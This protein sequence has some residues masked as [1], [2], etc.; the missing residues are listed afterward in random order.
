MNYTLITETDMYE[1]DT[2]CIIE[3]DPFIIFQNGKNELKFNR[4]YVV[5]FFPSDMQ[6]KK[7]SFSDL[8]NE[9][10]INSLANWTHN[11]NNLDEN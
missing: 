3:S 2:K 5:A 11:N 8:Q 10:T 6:L 4:N 7:T 1:F 9:K